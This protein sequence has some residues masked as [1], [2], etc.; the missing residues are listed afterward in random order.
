MRKQ[1]SVEAVAK[2][3]KTFVFF[4]LLAGPK[5]CRTIHVLQYTQIYT[6]MLLN[7]EKKYSD[8]KEYCEWQCVCVCDPLHCFTFF[9][10]KRCETW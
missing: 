3:N 2:E 4:L 5:C 9:Q 8:K 6:F 1:T 7:E 10:C